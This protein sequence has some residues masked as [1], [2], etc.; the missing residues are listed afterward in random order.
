MSGVRRWEHFEYEERD[1]VATLTFSRPDRLNSLT[2]DVYADVRDLTDSLRSRGDEIRLLVIRGKGR[3][4]CSGGDVDEIIAKL[5][6]MD[7]RGVYEF[8]RMTGAC[9]R[10]L[11]EIPQPVIAAVNGI[12]AGAGAVLA[13]AADI[14]I[15]AE[16]ASFR[17]LFTSVGLSGGDMGVC[18]LLPRIVG[19]GRA[20]EALL[21]GGKI[22]SHEAEAWGLAS[23]VVPDAELDAAVAD[24]VAR[25]K[26][27]APWGLAM[28]KEML[29]RGASSDYSSAI[30]M[31]AWTQTL[32][33]RADDFREF[34]AGFTGKRKPEFRGR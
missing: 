31:E 32:L 2:F 26:E 14:R 17:F 8:A 12:A 30:E 28:T 21:L 7:T 23:R 15:L 11:R 24:Y 13:T 29:N 16:S 5:L 10:N 33:M 19:M 20:T 27:L 4:F 9:V 1:G 18:W 3:G 34:H 6:E 22:T 25:F